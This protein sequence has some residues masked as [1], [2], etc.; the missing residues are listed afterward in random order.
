MSLLSDYSELHKI[1]V[2]AYI[3]N[4]S[5]Q[6]TRIPL[7]SCILKRSCIV[8]VIS[9]DSITYLKRSCIVLDISMEIRNSGYRQTS[10]DFTLTPFLCILNYPQQTILYFRHAVLFS[11]A[12]WESH[13]MSPHY[14]TTHDII[15]SPFQLLTIADKC[16]E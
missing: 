8:F 11:S 15:T 9:S 5:V 7:Q 2:S 10:S 16:L 3:S 1:V 14:V 12:K 4:S 13:P 6:Y